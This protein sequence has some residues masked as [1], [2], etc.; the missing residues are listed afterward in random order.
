M[1]AMCS[2]P[3]SRTGPTARPAALAL[4]GLLTLALSACGASDAREIEETIKRFNPAAAEGNGAEACD[5]LTSAARAPAGGLRCEA[6]IDQLARLGGAQTK[7]RLAAV[8]VRNVRVSG[9]TATAESQIPT[10]SPATLQ[11]EKVTRP[12]FKWKRSNG[13]WKIA[14][15]GAS[16]GGGF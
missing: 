12:V 7:R 5:Q 3:V 9:D 8:E 2:A 16:S 1:Q 10:Q 6:T 11:L 15:L 14:S 13:E 4:G